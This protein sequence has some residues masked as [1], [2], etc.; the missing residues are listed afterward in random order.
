MYL[1][2]VLQQHRQQSL[3]LNKG[4]IIEGLSGSKAA[5]EFFYWKKAVVSILTRLLFFAII[6]TGFL[7]D[8]EEEANDR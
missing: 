8:R 4:R 6:E 1:L 7:A 5:G 2:L 3:R